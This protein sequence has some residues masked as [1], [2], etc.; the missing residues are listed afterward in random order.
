MTSVADFQTRLH[1]TGARPRLSVCL[2][3]RPSLYQA[4]PSNVPKAMLVLKAKVVTQTKL[5]PPV[6]LVPQVKFVPQSKLVPPVQACTQAKIVLSTPDI[7]ST[8]GLVPYVN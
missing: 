8:T 6:K 4:N 5:L 1:K 2:D 7:D 3:L